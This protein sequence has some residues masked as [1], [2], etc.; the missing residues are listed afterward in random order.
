VLVVYDRSL[1]LREAMASLLRSLADEFR[2]VAF[3][4]LDE[5]RRI[6]PE[7]LR[8]TTLVVVNLGRAHPD[9][10]EIGADTAELRR[11][12]PG[13]PLVG[14]VER[15]DAEGVAAALRRHFRGVVPTSLSA[16]ALLHAL[17]FVEAGGRF[18]PD[19]VLPLEFDEASLDD[20]GDLAPAGLAEAE[21]PRFTDELDVHFTP[22]ELEVLD[23]LR[24]GL[25][26]KLIAHNLNMKESTVK[27]HLR[28]IMRKLHL[29][30]RTQ[31]A[32]YAQRRFGGGD[33]D[34]E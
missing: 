29:S 27:I 21:A 18:V 20:A 4:S 22:R 2:V 11:R 3:G 13:V 14:L 26:N 31:V 15:G 10:P 34:A 17:R 25:P 7:L 12:L 24:L 30:S 28:H 9:D 6:D 19:T 33:N 8:H 16:R 32:L 5:M 1:L 23:R